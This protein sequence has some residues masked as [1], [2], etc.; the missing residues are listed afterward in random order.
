VD[1]QE[2]ITPGGLRLTPSCLSWKFSKSCGPGGQHVNTTESRVELRC[3]LPAAGLPDYLHDR[4][5]AA[6][7]ADIR[8]TC[9]SSRSQLKNRA[10]ALDRL[11]VQLDDAAKPPRTRRPSR[12]PR[13][14]NE[15]RLQSKRLTSGRKANR[16][17]KPDD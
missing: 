16:S 11:A 1:E 12:I 5:S 9:S 6:L 17:W 15:R 13:G 2:P 8:I 14:I 4:I 7:G 3:D 10:E